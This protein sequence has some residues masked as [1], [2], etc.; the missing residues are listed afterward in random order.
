MLDSQKLGRNFGIGILF[1]IMAW[2][3]YDHTLHISIPF[4]QNRLVNYLYQDGY[5]TPYP[6][7]HKLH[8]VSVGTD[9]NASK[10]LILSAHIWQLPL[11]LLGIGEKFGGFLDKPAK[12]SAY[13]KNLPDDDIVMFVDAYDVFINADEA[14]LVNAF[15][16]K[17]RPLVVAADNWLYPDIDVG[18]LYPNTPPE[19]LFR[20]LNSG[21]S[22][23][24]VSAYKKMIAWFKQDR[25]RD[26]Y[27]RR[28]HFGHDQR[29]FTSY[30]LAHQ[31]DVAL[32]H[33]QEIFACLNEVHHPGYYEIVSAETID[34]RLTMKNSM[35]FHGNGTSGKLY[36]FALYDRLI[37]RWKKS[38]MWGNTANIPWYLY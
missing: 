20:Y 32:D 23:G 15:K 29:C 28:Y 19:I 24:Y 36:F 14:R 9:W 22:I 8:V 12:L 34:N 11:T 18:R 13:L 27:G 3:V 35:V 30:Y 10:R 1:I 25:C 2:G 4:W 21:G 5:T 38:L 17:K 6:S 7:K 33:T 31:Q 37:L 26:A 16:K